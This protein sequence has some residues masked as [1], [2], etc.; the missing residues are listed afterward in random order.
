MAK[1]KHRAVEKRDSRTGAPHLSR[2]PQQSYL[3]QRLLAEMVI[4]LVKLF[5]GWLAT[6]HNL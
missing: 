5:F 1:K 2:E 3:S 4:G 6:R